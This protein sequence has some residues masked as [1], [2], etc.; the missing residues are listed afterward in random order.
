M[1]SR[2][3]RLTPHFKV[4][5]FRDWHTG[6]LP[7]AYMDNALRKLC[8]EVLE[9]LRS[10]FGR[11]HVYSGFRTPAT[12]AEVHGAAQSYHIYTARRRAPAADIGFDRGTPQ[13][14]AD[15]ADRM[16]VNGLGTYSTHI[17][18]DQREGRARW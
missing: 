7:P 17:H 18:V 13:Q 3:L 16:G 11:C 4:T 14:W 6:Q 10:R 8:I 5:E 15:A 2:R 9:P 12:N 1:A